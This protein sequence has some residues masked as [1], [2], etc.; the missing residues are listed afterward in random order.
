MTRAT[1]AT[2]LPGVTKGTNPD[3]S[4][5]SALEFVLA[6]RDGHLDRMWFLLSSE[7]KGMFQGRWSA[8]TRQLPYEVYP[9]AQS[10]SHPSFAEFARYVREEILVD[11]A[12]VN[13]QDLGVLPTHYLDSV[14]G[15][16]RI[17]TCVRGPMLIESE[18]AMPAIFIP[19][20]REDGHWRV[21]F[22]GFG[23]PE[24]PETVTGDIEVVC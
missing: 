10:V 1:E 14:R 21:H 9:V 11:W 22:P 7:T 24:Q 18:M 19:V 2:R 4:G 17:G 5:F 6:V 16:V 13:L 3:E 20:L 12:E 8:V 23:W 15:Y